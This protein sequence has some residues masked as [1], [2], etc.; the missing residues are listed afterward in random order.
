[1]GGFFFFLYEKKKKEEERG[2]GYN[3][4]IVENFSPRI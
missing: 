1:M 2:R 3:H 4:V